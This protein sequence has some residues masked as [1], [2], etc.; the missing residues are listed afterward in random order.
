MDGSHLIP[1]ITGPWG[2]IV[3][4]VIAFFLAVG[5][6]MIFMW[7]VT[8]KGIQE[9]V[10]P[11]FDDFKVICDKVING[12]KITQAEAIFAL[13]CAV[14]GG[15]RICGFLVFVGLLSTFL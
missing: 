4:K 1:A 13:S 10:I 8:R 15:L 9:C 11:R 3:D 6:G 2:D 5:L 12:K 14:E 7:I